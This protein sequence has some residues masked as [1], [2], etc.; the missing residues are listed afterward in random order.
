MVAATTFQSQ[1][2]SL[3]WPTNARSDSQNLSESLGKLTA[4]LEEAEQS[5]G[6]GSALLFRT[7]LSSAMAAVSRAL[8]T[9]S[10]K[11]S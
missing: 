1:L 4:V 11:V 5:E 10:A 9:V 8:H 3:P 7:E 6:F 2:A